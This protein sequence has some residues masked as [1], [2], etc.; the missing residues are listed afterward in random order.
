MLNKYF[1]NVNLQ[2]LIKKTHY[3]TKFKVFM[4]NGNEKNDGL[5]RKWLQ[6]RRLDVKLL[7]IER[8]VLTI[9]TLKF[10]RLIECTETFRLAWLFLTMFSKYSKVISFF[11]M[12][13]AT[14]FA[15]QER[16]FDLFSSTKMGN[17]DRFLSDMVVIIYCLTYQEGRCRVKNKEK[18]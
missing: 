7:R 6:Y 2:K 13:C 10:L 18:W 12:C 8:E 5:R 3:V 4:C 16:I 11:L 15:R 9:E 14:P 17:R 1:K